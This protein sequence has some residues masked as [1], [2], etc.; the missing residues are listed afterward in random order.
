MFHSRNSQYWERREVPHLEFHGVTFRRYMYL[1]KRELTSIL[2]LKGVLIHQIIPS[3]KVYLSSQVQ[4]PLCK[5]IVKQNDS[6]LTWV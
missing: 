2:I 5:Q 1:Q 6:K 3:I 4:L